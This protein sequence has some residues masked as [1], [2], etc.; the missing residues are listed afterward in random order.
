[1]SIQYV[2]F[3]RGV[4]VGGRGIVKMAALVEALAAAGFT[5]VRSYIQSGNILLT[6]KLSKDCVKDEVETCLSKAFDMQ[7]QA[8]VFMCKE[9]KQVVANA[10]EWW[11]ERDDWK[12]NILI[13]IPPHTAYEAAGQIG[14]LKPDIEALATGDSVLYQSVSWAAFGKSVTGKLAASPVYKFMTVRNYNTA[15]KLA[16]LCEG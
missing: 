6:S 3:L 12:H 9:W 13:M 14:Q 8:A 15:H 5:D 2:V 10:P 1:M 4:N 16:L 7:T 11:G